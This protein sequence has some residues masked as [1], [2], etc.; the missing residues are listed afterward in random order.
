MS[1]GKTSYL[2]YVDRRFFL[3]AK[4][5]LTYKQQI[6]RMKKKN[7]LISDDNF[8]KEI[9][10]SISYY[11]I[12]NGYK[13]IFETYYDEEDNI[14]KFTSKITLEDLH[15]VYI[16]DNA[17][18][19]LLFK[20]IIYIENTLKT[21]IA[22]NVA[23]RF[24]EKQEDYLDFRKYVSSEP[25]DRKNVINKVLDELNYNKNNHSVQHYKNNH[26]FT[27][28]WI[29]VKALYFGTT[30]NWYKVLPMA[31]KEDISKEYFRYSLIQDKE[32]QKE[33]ILVVLNLLHE[34]RNNIAHGSRTFLSNVSCELS[35]NLLLKAVTTDVLTEKEFLNGFGK[36][37]L[38]AVIVSIA[39]LINDPAIFRQYLVDLATITFGYNDSSLPL[40][41]KGNIY[42]TLNIPEDYVE[43]ITT[44]YNIK[45][46]TN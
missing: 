5:F 45:F 9:L 37:D 10:N 36:K 40:S 33:F 42:Q 26:S 4:N 30:L 20:Y 23:M 21:K 35:K 8:A 3:S 17:L 19:N 6:Q 7:V 25:L 31:I 1:L 29:A 28:P 22:Y 38:F 18:N 12:M 24:G 41:P 11:S 2:I 16:I 34:Y 15:K 43:K 32:E 27:P 13:D 14:E 39:I 44:L 46:T